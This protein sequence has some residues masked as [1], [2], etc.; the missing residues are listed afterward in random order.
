MLSFLFPLVPAPFLKDEPSLV[1]ACRFTEGP[2]PCVW[3]SAW[4][5]AEGVR[6][7]L[8]DPACQLSTGVPGSGTV[9]ACG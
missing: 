2:S 4:R 3:L 6:L 5:C 1:E 8:Q 7:S 9:R